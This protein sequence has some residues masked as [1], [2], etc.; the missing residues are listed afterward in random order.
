MRDWGKERREARVEEGQVRERKGE[1]EK[2]RGG[3]SGEGRGEDS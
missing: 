1:L 2:K 3:R